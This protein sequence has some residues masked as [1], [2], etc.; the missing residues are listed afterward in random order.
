[1]STSAPVATAGTFAA[2][3][4]RRG[5][6]FGFVRLAL[7]CLVILSHSWTLGGHGSEA[8]QAGT[9]ET[10]GRLAVYGFFAL[11]GFLIAQS[12]QST[13][14]VMRFFWHRALRIGPGYYACLLVT[15][16]VLSSMQRL[17]ESGSLAGHAQDIGAFLYAN[18]TLRIH[19]YSIGKTLSDHPYGYVWIGALWTLIYEFKCY[20][21][22]AVLGV[23]GIL[24]RAPLL[25]LLGYVATLAAVAVET[26]H[27]GALQSISP[28]WIDPPLIEFVPCF[29]AGMVAWLY[30][31][32][33]RSSGA[34][35]ALLFAGA[36]VVLCAWPAWFTLAAVATVPYVTLYLAARLPIRELERHGDLSYGMYLYGFPV[37]Q[38]L[39]TTG[40]AS[41]G[42]V[43]FALLAIVATV[44]FAAGS[45]FLVERP[46]LRLKNVSLPLALLWQRRMGK[47]A[48]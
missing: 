36:L 14:S 40:A 31:D 30:R 1:M 32:R 20:V 37:Q 28:L 11:S 33:I 44:P 38:L 42:P 17:W 6:S 39:V 2:L 22:A 48:S 25:V 21:L 23:T 16:L 47:N 43:V 9:K 27:E 35:A 12:Y 18:K 7:A 10:L 4:S 34:L 3:L 13:G 15:A 5:N 45:W 26:A 8:L 24:R 29:L 19:S 46:M 41:L